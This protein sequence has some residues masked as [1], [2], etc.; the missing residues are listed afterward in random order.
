M[1]IPHFWN[2]FS[3]LPFVLVGAWLLGLLIAVPTRDASG[4]ETEF[5]RLVW[6]IFAL[7]VILTGFGSSYYHVAPDTNRLFWDRL[8][9]TIAFMGLFSAVITERVDP[10]LGRALLWPL[11]ALGVGSAVWWRYSESIGAGDLRLYGVVQFYPLAAIPVI[12]WRYPARYSHG[13]W[14]ICAVAWYGAAK[15]ME[16]WDDR[17]FQA[18]DHLFSGHSLKHLLAAAAT[19][20]IAAMVVRRRV[21]QPTESSSGIAAPQADTGR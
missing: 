10:D 11:L 7:G 14:L 9:M 5:E 20:Q 4:Y 16:L 2:V 17:L 6:M 19:A 18:T 15:V 21:L 13:S 1:A 8:P 3:N 12:L